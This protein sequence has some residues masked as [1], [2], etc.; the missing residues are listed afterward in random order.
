MKL[1]YR[2]LLLL[3]VCGM[4]AAFYPSHDSQAQANSSPDPKVTPLLAGLQAQQ[5]LMDE[6][7]SQI[8]TKLAAVKEDIRLAKIFVARGGGGGGGTNK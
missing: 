7:Q 6:Q 2:T 1:Q 3:V 8:E 5:K 4:G